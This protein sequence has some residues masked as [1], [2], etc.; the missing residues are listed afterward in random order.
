MRV[1]IFCHSL[2]SDWNHGNAHFLRGIATELLA[3]G[4]EVRVF[5]PTDAWSVQNLVQEAGE[6]AIEGFHRAYPALSSSRV[7]LSRLD[8]DEALDAADVVLVHEWIEHPLVERIGR[9]HAARGGYVLLFHDTH[10]RSVTDPESMASYDLQ[11]YD[12]VLAFGDVIRERYTTH[13]WGRRAWTW[14]EAADVRVFRPLE[15]AERDGD[16]VWIGNWGDDERTEEIR[17]FLIEPVRDLALRARVHGVR[18]PETARAEL[19]SAG[20]QYGGWLPN[21]RVPELF[22]RYAATVHIP[23]R[24]YVEALP[25]I[26]TIR[27]FEALACGIPLVSLWWDDREGLF[28]AGRDFLVARTPADMRRLL[29][30]VLR[31]RALAT[32]LTRHG[33][34]TIGNRHTCAHRVDELLAIVQRVNGTPAEVLIA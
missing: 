13:G 4:H 12:G 29:T 33:L 30:D 34:A 24:P 31:D 6:S 27:V 14:H 8:L 32:E 9:H 5:E 11:H 3:R 28:A 2:V 17:R 19:A 7:D 25:G 20:I 26:P 22:A 1:V 23:R 16:L 10:H 18:Y 15:S 21:Y